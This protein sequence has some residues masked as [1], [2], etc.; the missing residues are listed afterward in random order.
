MRSLAANFPLASVYLKLFLTA[1]FWGGTF[2]AGKMTAAN[3]GPFSAAFIRF[4]FASALLLVLVKRVEG[5][6]P[7]IQRNMIVPL[8]LLGMTG[9]FFY[10][11]FF[12]KGLKLIHASRAALIIANNPVFITIFASIIFKERLALPQIFGIALSVSGAMVVISKGDLASIFYVGV[13]WGEV[14]IFGCVA[15]WVAYSL[16]G[17]AV[18]TKLSPLVSVA[19]SAL[20]GDF[21]LFVP[22][23]CEGLFT[24]MFLYTAS[25]WLA[26]SYL[27]V[28]GTVFGFVWYYQGIKSLGP[29]KAG[30]FINFVP[31]SAVILSYFFLNE[32]LTFSL[33]I[34]AVLVVSGVYLTNASRLFAGKS[35]KTV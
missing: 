31:V 30:L 1:V 17:K 19:L 13:G 32:P 18:V 3:V 20:A 35:K 10:N 34:G 29:V 9:V 26:L 7:S 25:D 15:S 4:F 28:F 24:D 11:F 16:L 27:G 14:F 5:R 8:I 12:F 2:I 21:L 6:F 33:V 22:A 23:V